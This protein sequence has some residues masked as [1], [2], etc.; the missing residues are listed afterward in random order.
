[1]KALVRTTGDFSLYFMN[2][3]N[4]VAQK[5]RPS[6]VP[7]NHFFNQRLGLNQLKVLKSDLPDEAKD[8][9]FAKYLEDTD[10][11]AELA[12]DSYLS[13]LGEKEPEQSEQKPLE[14]LSDEQREA[15]AAA[16]A[17]AVAAGAKKEDSAK[18]PADAAKK[19]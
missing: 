1:M 13:T 18:T 17:A 5:N 3:D 6:I 19:D 8:A 10:G 14:E 15:A 7:V 12:L 2:D 11:D 9:D 16:A 4:D